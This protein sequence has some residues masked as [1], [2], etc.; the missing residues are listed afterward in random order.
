MGGLGAVTPAGFQSAVPLCWGL[1]PEASILF[2]D[3][4][5]WQVNDTNTKL[6]LFQPFSSFL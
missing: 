1:P 2:K 5:V 6:I 4:N 3:K